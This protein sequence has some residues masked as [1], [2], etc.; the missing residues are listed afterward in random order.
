MIALLNIKLNDSK[1]IYLLHINFN[2][3]QFKEMMRNHIKLYSE[4]N[5]SE[6]FEK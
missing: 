3:I 4:T 5:F 1:N 6:K 2:T